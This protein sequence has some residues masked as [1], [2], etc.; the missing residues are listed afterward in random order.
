MYIWKGIIL[1]KQKRNRN[2]PAESILSYLS[3]LCHTP[4]PEAKKTS[5][6]GKGEGA[7]W[8]NSLYKEIDESMD[9]VDQRREVGS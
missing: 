8:G 3:T 6:Y 4:A 9:G 1:I 5:M 7:G 2:R